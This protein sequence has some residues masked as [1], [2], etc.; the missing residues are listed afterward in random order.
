MFVRWIT[1]KN[2]EHL[3]EAKS[4]HFERLISGGPVKNLLS[5]RLEHT[6]GGETQLDIPRD[7]DELYIMNNNGRTIDSY[8]W[9]V[10]QTVAQN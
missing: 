3:Y 7:G 10:N 5:V 8:Q 4:I 9:E 2:I 1:N 6:G